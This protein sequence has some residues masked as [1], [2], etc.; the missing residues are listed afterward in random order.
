MDLDAKSLC[1]I[2]EL[3]EED[4]VFSMVN[5]DVL[6]IDTTIGEMES[7]VLLR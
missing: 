4:P 7:S 1:S 6:S 3:E 5:E 2:R